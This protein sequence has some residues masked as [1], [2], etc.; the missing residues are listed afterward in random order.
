[1]SIVRNH[2]DVSIEHHDRGKLLPGRWDSRQEGVAKHDAASRPTLEDAYA[3]Q[4]RARQ[5]QAQAQAVRDGALFLAR[6]VARGVRRLALATAS[7]FVA[8]GEAL[9]AK[10]AYEELSRLSDH[11]LA[12][13]GLTRDDIPAVVWG[14]LRRDK[15]IVD[16][17]EAAA[18][19]D[20]AQRFRKAA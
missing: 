1:M 14:G 5:L 18:T 11:H 2:H 20:V 12:D 15:D 7:W 6:G 4:A 19:D 13:M 10:R 16:V 3:L 9:A 8:A 17:P